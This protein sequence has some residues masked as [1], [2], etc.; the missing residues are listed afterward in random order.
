MMA[1]RITLTM[2]ELELMVSAIDRACRA[3]DAQEQPEY[4]DLFN[5]V[6]DLE[7]G[8]EYE[9]KCTVEGQI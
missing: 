2:E 8:L 3:S 1:K 7:M 5:K 4:V 6:T 9:L